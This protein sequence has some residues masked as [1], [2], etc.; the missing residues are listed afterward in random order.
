MIEINMHQIFRGNLK[1]AQKVGAQVWNWID[2][3][4]GH[5][6]PSFG[7]LSASNKDLDKYIS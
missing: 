1:D 7:Q 4:D 2:D 6:R 5:C 3:S